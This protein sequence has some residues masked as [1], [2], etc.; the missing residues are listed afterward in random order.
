VALAYTSSGGWPVVI[1]NY[2]SIS[3]VVAVAPT[4][5]APGTYVLQVTPTA[6]SPQLSDTSCQLF[7]VDQTGTQTSQDGSGNNTSTTCWP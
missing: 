6:G 7:Q 5:S 2:Y 3:S 4:S 1:G